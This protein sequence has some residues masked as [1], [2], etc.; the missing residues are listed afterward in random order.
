[1]GLEDLMKEVSSELERLVSTKTVVGDAVTIG[2]TTIIP[3]T[4]VSFGFGTGG[5][6]GKSKNNEEGFGG[7]GAAG[8]KIEPVAFI[9][10]SKEETRLM[11]ISGKSDIGVL[12]ESVPG[13]IDKIKTMKGKKDKVNDNTD[14]ADKSV[15]SVEIE[16]E[17]Q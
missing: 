16:V 13:L 2:D 10:I 17:G 11:S 14:T 4:K 8:A 6:E 1:M 5:G 15:G 9:V 7:G 3:V 12:L